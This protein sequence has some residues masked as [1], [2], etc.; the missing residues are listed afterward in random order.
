[1][2]LQLLDLYSKPHDYK[3]NDEEIAFIASQIS[4]NSFECFYA[5]YNKKS[6][7]GA[8]IVFVIDSM[9]NSRRS[10]VMN[11]RGKFKKS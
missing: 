10:L 7:K 6:S 9:P 1:M 2:S 4:K 8:Y 5:I 11:N 3:F